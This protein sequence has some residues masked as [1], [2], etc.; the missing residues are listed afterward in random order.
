MGH[1]G[2]VDIIIILTQFEFNLG[3]TCNQLKKMVVYIN[4]NIER[5][6]D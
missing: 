5:N 3:L 1:R 2:M 4:C 6:S